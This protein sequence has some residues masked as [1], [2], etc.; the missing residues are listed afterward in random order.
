V[1]HRQQAVVVLAAATRFAAGILMGTGLAFFI[2]RAGGSDFAVGMVSTAY[3]LGVMV[4]SPVWG[5]VADVTGRGRTVLAVTGLGATAAALLLVVLEG[6]WTQVGARALY[7]TFAAGFPPV[8]LA[9]VSASGGRAG[10]GRSLGFFNSARAAGFTGGQL[11]AGVLTGLLA[12]AGLHLVVAGLSLASTL[13]VLVVDT[14]PH[15]GRLPDE[16]DRA[17]GARAVLAAVRRRLLPAI[18]DRGHLRQNGLRFLYVALALRN[19][20]VL[21]V[22]ALMPVYL[23]VELEFR[24]AVWGALLASNHAGQVAFMYLFGR[25]ADAVGRV[26]LVALGMAGSGAFALLA[27]GADLPPPGPVRLAVAAG[28]FLL[29]AAS[30]SAL[31]TGALAFIGDVAPADRE[32]ELMGLRSTAK[33][34]GGVVGP[35][36]FGAVATV[37]GYR[38][39]FAVGSLLAFAGAVTAALALTETRGTTP[40]GT[41]AGADDD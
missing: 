20:T 9:V 10:R 30:Y 15:S 7:A 37:A 2:G 1:R 25:A 11:G 38:A 16:A 4:C 35:A 32:S 31:T 29:L 13:A 36:L 17:N 26:V 23:P 8:M 41:G 40:V 28:A 12:P 27:A 6:V 22:M 33:G 34:V 21:G 3:F 18:G 5:A 14:S 39:T 24:A 19:V